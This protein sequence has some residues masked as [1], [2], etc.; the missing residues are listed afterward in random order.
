MLL[1]YMDDIDDRC[2]LYWYY[3]P[4]VDIDTGPK[5]LNHGIYSIEQ[6]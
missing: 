1:T 6:T 5:I 3:K 4:L 2:W